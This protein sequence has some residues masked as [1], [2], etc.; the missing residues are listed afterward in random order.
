MIENITIGELLKKL[1]GG[2]TVGA[3]GSINKTL[4][5]SS[6]VAAIAENYP[7]PP[8]GGGYLVVEALSLEDEIYQSKQLGY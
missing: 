7:T 5:A 1:P 3:D 4:L 8:D 2:F 6:W